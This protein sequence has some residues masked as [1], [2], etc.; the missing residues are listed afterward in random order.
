MTEDL[1]GIL[2]LLSPA[3]TKEDRALIALAYE[4]ARV[5]HEGH[6]RYSGE[7]YLTHLVA[8]ARSLAEMG[9][10]A[11]TIAA[12]LL[13]DVIEDTKVTAEQLRETFGEEIL[14]LV[15]G[16]TKLGSVRYRGT[17]RHNESLR[18]LFV[19]TSQEIRVLIV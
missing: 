10:G 11:Q 4:C 16:V 7:P 2:T 18:K 3:A 1:E 13:H 8:V 12:G 6:T 19:A 15:E 9:M 5:A 14:F 17:D